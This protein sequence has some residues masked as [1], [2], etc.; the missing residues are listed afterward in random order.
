MR[1]FQRT[2][3]GVLGTP[4]LS[5]LLGHIPPGRNGKEG[6]S[7]TFTECPCGGEAWVRLLQH[8]LRLPAAQG[9]SG[10]GGNPPG[11]GAAPA[12]SCC[13]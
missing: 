9:D 10:N 6:D 7:Q 2:W 3:S 4:V 8:V 5:C 13:M 11:E 1:I 12:C